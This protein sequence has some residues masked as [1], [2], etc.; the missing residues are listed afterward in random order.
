MRPPQAAIVVTTVG[1][2]GRI[3]TLPHL[4]AQKRPLKLVPTTTTL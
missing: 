3:A 1:M 2:V 4:V